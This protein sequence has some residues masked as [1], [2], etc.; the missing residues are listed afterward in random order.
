[1]RFECIGVFPCDK[2]QNNPALFK[3][4][5]TMETIIIPMV[6]LIKDIISIKRHGMIANE[7]TFPQNTN[8]VKL[9]TTYRS[10]CSPQQIMHSMQ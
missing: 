2:S 9:A 7:T 10:A 8:D 1:M 3:K 5:K 6:T 4:S